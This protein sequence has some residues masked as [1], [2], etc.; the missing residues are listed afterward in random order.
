MYVHIASFIFGLVNVAGNVKPHHGQPNVAEGLHIRN[1]LHIANMS[2]LK[3]VLQMTLTLHKARQA[4]CPAPGV[5]CR[6]HSHA[7]HTFH[8]LSVTCD[9]FLV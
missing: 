7:P 2:L 9:M 4:G 6:L 1:P 8:I 5:Q 3:A